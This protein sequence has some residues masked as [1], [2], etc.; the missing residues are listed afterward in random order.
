MSSASPADLESRLLKVFRR[1]AASVPAYREI[2]AEHGVSA[3]QIAD[4]AAFV[5]LCPLLRKANTFQRFPIAALCV[6][7]TIGDLAGVLTS[8]GHGGSFS[9]G[10]VDRKDAALHAAFTDHALDQ[11]FG[12]ASRRTLAIN[13]LPMGVG[14]ATHCMTLAT[15]SVR[16]DMVAALVQTFGAHYEQIVLV[17]DP[18]FLKRLLDHAEERGLDWSRHRVG[19]VLG[20]EIFGERYRAYVTAR[21]GLDAAAPERGYVMSSFGVGE[22]GLHLCYE[23]PATIAL[24]RA[25]AAAPALAEALFGPD[26]G[27]T[28]LPMVF[29]YDPARTF[30]E[31]VDADAAGDGRL[32]ISLLDAELSLPLLRYQ[33]G[34]TARLLDAG[35]VQALA[36]AHGVTLPGALPPLLVALKG[37]DKEALPNGSHVGVFKDAL[38]ADHDA[39]RAVTGACRLVFEGGASTLHVQLRRGPSAP[40][41]G[42]AAAIA[43]ALPAAAR[44]G[45]IAIWPYA[46]FPYGMGLDYERKFTYVG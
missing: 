32:T 43:A 34:D 31:V 41:A 35:R 46:T 18:L 4:L 24:R 10:V 6:G 20:E 23:T 13:C 22:L 38:Y 16:E 15:T 33:T 26:A 9:F 42:L 11:A 7:G 3:D 21:L 40:P 19:A 44:P 12:V 1:A 27:A 5:R 45:R 2:L 39:A 25:A 14:L 36:A 28:A 17:A 37:R 8:S 29:T 30:V